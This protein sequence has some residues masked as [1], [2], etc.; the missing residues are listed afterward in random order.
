MNEKLHS[1]Q[2]VFIVYMIQSGVTIFALP[3]IVAE[4]YGTN[5]WVGLIIMSAIVCMNLYFIY[6]VYKK[7]DGRSVFEIWEKKIT[8]VL[9]FP[10][11][12]LMI[13]FSLILAIMITNNYALLIKLMLFKE[14]HLSVLVSIILIIV[15]FLLNKGVYNVA[16]VT[17]VFFFIIILYVFLIPAV[18]PD[19]QFTRMTTHF[20]KGDLDIWHGSVKVYTA[21]LGYSIILFL[22]PFMEKNCR[23]GRAMY[24]GHFLTTAIYLFICIVSFGFFSFEQLKNTLY[25]TL[26]LLKYVQTPVIERIEN[27]TFSAFLLSTII[28]TSYYY[29]LAVEFLKRFFKK[30]N[31]SQLIFSVIL[32]TFIISLFVEKKREIDYLLY[33]AIYPYIV[34]SFLLPLLALLALKLDKKR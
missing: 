30:A 12:F 23:L 33:I 16:K 5:G 1:S 4:A 13:G 34:M 20:F 32:L 31:E 3:R 9:L 26:M 21:F 15:L 6:L 28:T 2:I 11:Y 18:L 17:S 10:V 22:F 24:I 8:K 25:P 29:W 27:V 19:F 7:G 14:V